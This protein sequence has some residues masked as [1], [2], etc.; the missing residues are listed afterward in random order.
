[1]SLCVNLL[2]NKR[3]KIDDRVFQPERAQNALNYLSLK[4][5]MLH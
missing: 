1:M 2:K 5:G 4:G 3:L